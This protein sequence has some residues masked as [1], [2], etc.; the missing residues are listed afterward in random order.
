LQDS[1]TAEQQNSRTAEQQNSRKGKLRQKKLKLWGLPTLLLRAIK[2][3]NEKS[4]EKSIFIAN[5]N[6]KGGIA[7]E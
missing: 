4:N 3:S 5:R 2:K 6:R 7:A 1:R